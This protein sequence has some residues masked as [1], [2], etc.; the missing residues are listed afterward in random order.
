MEGSSHNTSDGKNCFGEGGKEK[1]K[2]RQ[3]EVRGG[4][5]FQILRAELWG[6]TLGEPG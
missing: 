3:H 5:R 2:K 6:A 4:G 1:N